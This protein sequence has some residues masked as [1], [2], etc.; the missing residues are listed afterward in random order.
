M[1]TIFKPRATGHYV[2]PMMKATG[3]RILKIHQ[4]SANSNLQAADLDYYIN[5]SIL[6]LIS[7]SFIPT[8]FDKKA[9]VPQKA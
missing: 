1:F 3:Y 2:Q 6:Q 4:Q 9:Y 5:Y 7:I 8:R